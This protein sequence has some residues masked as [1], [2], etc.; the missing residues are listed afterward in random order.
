[1]CLIVGMQP[2]FKQEMMNN[3]I[4]PRRLGPA[5]NHQ[6]YNEAVLLRRSTSK[7]VV[8]AFLPS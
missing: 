1:M 4:E 2:V 7:P 6:E 5:K 3:H 8:L